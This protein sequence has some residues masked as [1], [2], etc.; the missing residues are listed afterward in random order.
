M[1][2]YRNIIVAIDYSDSSKV[3]LLQAQQ[4][5]RESGARLLAFH[6]ISPIELENYA[7][8]YTVD[9]I[10]LVE[11]ALHFL[12]EW[13]EEFLGEDHGVVCQVRE[14]IPH[15]EV[16][17]LTQETAT[18]LLVI[19]S[20]E[21][22][23]APDRS[24]KFAIKCLRFMTIPILLAREGCDYPY[25][26]IDAFVDFSASTK[27][28]MEATDR[29]VGS[30]DPEIRVVHATCPPWLKTLRFRIFAEPARLEE[31]KVQYREI[32]QGQL[33]SVCQKFRDLL[34]SPPTATVLEGGHLERTIL[35]HLSESKTS[36]AILGR[37]GEGA[38]GM[39][40]DILGGTAEALLRFAKCSVLAVPFLD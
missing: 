35:S 4:I 40:N 17:A 22:S 19:G 11:E 21:Y 31:Q 33:E 16:A 24:G 7:V 25:S 8:Y 38:K 37:S 26:R 36:L 10:P 9:H 20:K 18:D 29:F 27:S 28:V 2:P 1:K 14:G 13:V 15:H 5:S 39:K 30:H 34:P 23:D 12:E 3:A 6:A 32:M